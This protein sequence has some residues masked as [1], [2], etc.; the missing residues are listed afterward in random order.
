MSEVEEVGQKLLADCI[1]CITIHGQ[2]E[3]AQRD[4]AIQHVKDGK[5][6]VLI[7]TDVCSRGL[8]IPMIHVVVNYDMPKSIEDFIH[9]IGRT[10][11]AGQAGIA[12]SFVTQRDKDNLGWQLKE[13]MTENGMEVD[14]LFVNC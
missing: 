1:P 6:S 13:L 11:R 8:H 5:V 14:P 7:S 9:R 2:A 4:R 10:A 12:L 3:Q